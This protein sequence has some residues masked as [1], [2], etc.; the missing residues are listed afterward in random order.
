HPGGGLVRTLVS[1]SANSGA[2]TSIF[3]YCGRD[4]TIPSG[5]GHLNRT[6]TESYWIKIR[7][8]LLQVRYILRDNTSTSGWWE[9]MRTVDIQ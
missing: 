7:V 2:K 5:T 8:P 4:R 9:K 6:G 3:T 1:F